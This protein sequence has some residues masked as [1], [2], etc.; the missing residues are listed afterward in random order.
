MKKNLQLAAM[1]VCLFFLSLAGVNAQTLVASWEAEDYV[2]WGWKPD[3]NNFPV[4][5]SAGHSGG[6]YIQ[7]VS[8]SN[9]A[10]Y[11]INVANAGVYDL[12][13]YYMI[14]ADGGQI[15]SDI[16][17][18]VN[19]QIIRST[20]VTEYTT[21]DSSTETKTITF[22]VYL[23]AG[24]NM[25]RI[26][27]NTIIPGATSYTPNFDKFELYTSIESLEKPETDVNYETTNNIKTY[28][29]L[30]SYTALNSI[31]NDQT[32][33]TLFTL[34]SDTENPTTQ[35]LIDNNT[36]T[37]FTSTEDT[38]TFTLHFPHGSGFALRNI[39]FDTN[40]VILSS[41]LIQRSKTG[42]EGSWENINVDARFISL[43]YGNTGTANGEWK[44]GYNSSY[45]YKY[46]RFTIKK[47]PGATNIEIGDM[48][49]YGLYQGLVDLADDTNG[50]VSTSNTSIDGSNVVSRAIINDATLKFSV[51][52]AN[53]DVIYTF[54]NYARIKAYSLA[55]AATP[56]GRDPKSWKLEGT[57]DGENYV[58]LDTVANYTWFIDRR[59]Q[60]IR[61]IEN[62]GI[63]K[64]YKMTVTAKQGTDSYLHVGEFQVFGTLETSLTTGTQNPENNS[65]IS[66]YASEKSIV[67]NNPA[68]QVVL[69][70][71]YDTTGKQVKSGIAGTSQN[72]I[73]MQNGMYLIKTRVGNTISTSK[74]IIY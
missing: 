35:N 17:V 71:I 4:V 29:G 52:G 73:N 57:I 65:N 43:F 45:D 20:T 27:Q 44:T 23:D 16:G 11:F 25:L 6:W 15:G 47:I 3:A 66:V 72:E 50:T 5:Q 64:T 1:A 54:N 28:A 74:V 67:I 56:G 62:P 18:R 53:L 46:Y 32:S 55:N 60:D 48:K 37:K 19:D 9:S 51:N 61:V 40:E 42:E 39:V 26:G 59:C 24:V 21:S 10:I 33:T 36:S 70:Q 12:K 68:N 2:G 13:M 49:V 30:D 41:H 34:T 58:L 8:P 31:Y 63:Y 22:P 38:V 7:R 14:L 69:Y